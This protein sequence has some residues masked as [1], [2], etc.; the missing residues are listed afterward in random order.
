MTEG[1]DDHGRKMLHRIIDESDGVEVH[2]MVEDPIEASVPE[3]EL[4]VGTVKSR[5]DVGEILVRSGFVKWEKSSDASSG[6][7]MSNFLVEDMESTH[8]IELVANNDKENVSLCVN[9]S[10][11]TIISESSILNVDVDTEVATT[12]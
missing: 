10:T 6:T 9:M 1:L 3:V 7:L 12:R 11:E 8:A 2:T 4:K 5:Q